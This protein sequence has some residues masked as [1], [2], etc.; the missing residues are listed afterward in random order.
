MSDRCCKTP[1]PDLATPAPQ[2]IGEKE[3]VR[4]VIR[5]DHLNIPPVNEI[6]LTPYREI[7]NSDVTSAL[8][9][10][11][12]LMQKLKKILDKISYKSSVMLRDQKEV[13]FPGSF[14]H[15]SLFK[16]SNRYEW[17][18]F[19][20]LYIGIYW[21]DHYQVLPEL[22][23]TLYNRR[24]IKLFS[25]RQGKTSIYT[26]NKANMIVSCSILVYDVVEFCTI[27]FRLLCRIS[28]HPDTWD[29]SLHNIIGKPRNSS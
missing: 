7:L 20:H 19:V 12:H 4:V 5:N 24:G 8:N 2:T 17:H 14:I 9:L 27:P 10:Q 18:F 23:N 22:N 11:W 13:T 3:T 26:F 21:G 25:L 16:N 1:Q 6:F 28:P 29:P 15:T